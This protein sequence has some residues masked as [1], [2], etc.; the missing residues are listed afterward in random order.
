MKHKFVVIKDETSVYQECSG[1]K[2]V[3]YPE[4]HNIKLGTCLSQEMQD[5]L[6]FYL[7]KEEEESNNK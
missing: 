6:A 5:A 3:V 4:E 1:C 7:K 2:M